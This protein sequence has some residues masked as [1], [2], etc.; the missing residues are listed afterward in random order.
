MSYLGISTKAV[1]RLRRRR[2]GRSRTTSWHILS[3]FASRRVAGVSVVLAVIGFAIGIYG[4]R[5]LEIGDL[6]PGAPELH[7]D[8]RYNL[9]NQFISDNYATSSDVF[10]VMVETAEQQCA[11]Y[12]NLELVDRFIWHMQNVPGVS[13]AI[14]ATE[15]SK[16]IAAGYNEGNLK[17]ATISRNQR[18]LSSTFDPIPYE[19]VNT[20]CSMLPVA[21]FLS[22]HKSDTLQRVVDAAQDIRAAKRAGRHS[23]CPGGRQRRHRGGHQ[24]GNRQLAKPHADPDLRCRGRPGVYHVLRRGAP[25]SALWCRW[26]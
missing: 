20:T 16:L 14:G 10:V 7:P 26:P 8:S 6:D 1:E 4:G 3:Y 24:P 17:W 25:S 12:S 11:Q 15:I 9:D 21:L 19:L 22:D 23:L 2:A 13:S 5:N 18:L